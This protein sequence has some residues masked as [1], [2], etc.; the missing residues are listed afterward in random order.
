[1]RTQWP[2]MKGCDLW[3]CTYSRQDLLTLHTQEQSPICASHVVS[4]DTEVQDREWDGWSSKENIMN[5][6][7]S[8]H[9]PL[10]CISG[11]TWPTSWWPRCCYAVYTISTSVGS[12]RVTVNFTR[13]PTT[14]GRSC[15]TA[16]PAA[17]MVTTE[18]YSWKILLALPCQ[19]IK[20]DVHHKQ[21]PTQ[22]ETQCWTPLICI[23]TAN[24]QTFNGW[25]VTRSL[26][27]SCWEHWWTRGFV[28]VQLKGS[29][30]LALAQQVRHT[31]PL[32]CN[33]VHKEKEMCKQYLEPRYFIVTYNCMIHTC[34]DV[35]T[36]TIVIPNAQWMDTTY[37]V[38]TS[39]L[40]VQS[41]K[42]TWRQWQH[43]SAILHNFYSAVQLTTL[44][45]HLYWTTVLFI[46]T[47]ISTAMNCSE[48]E[49]RITAGWSN[50]MQLYQGCQPGVVSEPI[51]PHKLT[52][53]A[54]ILPIPTSYY[55]SKLLWHLSWI[56]PIRMLLASC[57]Y[58]A[59]P[60]QSV[61]DCSRHFGKFGWLLSLDLM[62]IYQLPISA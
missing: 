18:N 44:P 27:H 56:V 30:A 23:Q 39:V 61:V 12:G 43:N 37:I 13:R 31:N 55:I 8:S 47:M 17:K 7:V 42:N 48:E 26:Q 15:A 51:Y 32:Q 24:W 2:C 29:D 34:H 4:V 40:G 62:P 41:Y 1:M 36:N 46:W 53:N 59:Y 14:L 28:E 49:H 22:Q 19:L 60:C 5:K 58:T 11:E 21:A 38:C 54:E 45:T 6:I 3:L 25:T 57:L 20:R 10:L 9:N 35:L 50:F 52:T 16:G 33:I